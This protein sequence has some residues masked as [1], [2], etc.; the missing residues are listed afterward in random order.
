MINP[1]LISMT[2]PVRRGT[3]RTWGEH[4]WGR[5]RSTKLRCQW[6]HQI[7]AY[8]PSIG[9]PHVRIRR[10]NQRRW[11]PEGMVV[12]LTVP[13]SVHRV[14]LRPNIKRIPALKLVTA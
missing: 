4:P 5:S 6:I 1:E 12:M 8:T 14:L 9:L 3:E 7:L 10:Y 13:R 11:M 2:W